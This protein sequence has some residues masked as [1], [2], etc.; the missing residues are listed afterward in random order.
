MAPARAEWFR[1]ATRM[2]S[3][4]LLGLLQGRK[5]AKTPVT[6]KCIPTNKSR[7]DIILTWCSLGYRARKCQTITRFRLRIQPPARIMIYKNTKSI[8]AA[9]FCKVTCIRVLHRLRWR[10]F[11]TTW[12]TLIPAITNRV[13]S[14]TNIVLQY[15]HLWD[16]K[17]LYSL[18][19]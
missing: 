16:P 8:W 13:T 18:N 14:E 3:W 15:K 2:K 7:S 12:C 9:P 11:Q 19:I 5:A 17:N 6:I 1:L 4:I 10:Q